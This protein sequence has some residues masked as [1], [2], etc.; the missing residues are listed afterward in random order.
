MEMVRSGNS[1]EH[2]GSGYASFCQAKKGCELGR[3]MAKTELEM[4]FSAGWQ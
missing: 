3:R 2:V 1:R 4:Q